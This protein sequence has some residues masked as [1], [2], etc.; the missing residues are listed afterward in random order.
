MRVG[1]QPGYARTPHYAHARAT[2]PSLLP[3]PTHLAH[4]GP[5]TA[6]AA[7]VLGLYEVIPARGT[8]EE[9]PHDVGDERH[10]LVHACRA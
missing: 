1:V 9:V 6:E 8:T 3:A 4:G 7:L 10:C 5:P 2:K